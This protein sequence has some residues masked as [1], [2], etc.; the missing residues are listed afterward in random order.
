MRKLGLC[1]AIIA[2]IHLAIQCIWYLRTGNYYGHTNY[3][4]QPVGTL[5]LAAIGVVGI[6]VGLIIAVNKAKTLIDKRH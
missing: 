4:N 2:I 3:W 1:V 5:L 6:V